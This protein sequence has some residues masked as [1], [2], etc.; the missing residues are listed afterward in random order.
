MA[1]SASPAGYS[2]HLNIRI[3]L[4]ENLAK[5]GT[6]DSSISNIITK[7]RQ[8]ITKSLETDHNKLT[9]DMV[10][11]LLD[12]F[13]KSLET[14]CNV[15]NS[16]K[17]LE[18]ANS[19]ISACSLTKSY[20]QAAGTTNQNPSNRT[21]KHMLKIFPKDPN[22][23]KS[24]E[25][26]KNF[27]INKLDINTIDANI[28]AIKPIGRGGVSILLNKKDEVDNLKEAVDKSKE[29]VTKV[30][31]KTR[32]SFSF[33]VEGKDH[34]IDKLKLTLIKKNETLTAEAF[35]I[36]HIRYPPQHNFSIVYI[37]INPALYQTFTSKDFRLFLGCGATKLREC[38]P[39]TQCHNC[40]K[41]GHKMAKCRYEENGTKISR[42]GCRGSNNFD[43]NCSKDLACP[44]CSDFNKKV[45]KTIHQCNHI[46]NDPNCPSRIN[47]E[48]IAKERIDYGN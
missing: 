17:E 31:E 47:A 35:D 6:T 21:T 20:A 45:R 7:S 16:N 10:L 32:P 48:K 15:A 19:K 25:A 5:L 9:K 13:I 18:L 2:E 12:S 42:C 14:L 27:L 24:S 43:T 37:N 26:T 8:A 44:N 39:L 4:K 38:N 34:T 22:S 1:P 33:I 36:V 23:F 29:L 28:R 11:N 40:C 30:D 3:K 46:A 41:F